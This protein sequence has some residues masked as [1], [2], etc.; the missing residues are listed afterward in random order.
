MG[1]VRSS[2]TPAK[3]SPHTESARTGGGRR[4]GRP[5]P[6]STAPHEKARAWAKR[7]KARARA[8]PPL[9]SCGG[10]REGEG[11]REGG[12][13][14]ASQCR[15]VTLQASPEEIALSCLYLI[16][17]LGDQSPWG[18]LSVLRAGCTK[19][20]ARA[21]SIWWQDD[22]SWLVMDVAITSLARVRLAAEKK[23]RG[24]WF[25]P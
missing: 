10:W 19:S 14:R 3:G 24:V 20:C 13:R 15:G 12:V 6:A 8:M 25:P 9:V 4:A 7:K 16:W 18:G 21:A 1:V 17:N 5:V 11:R 23:C 2:L 22:G